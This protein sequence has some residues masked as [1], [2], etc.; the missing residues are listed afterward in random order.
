MRAPD[1]RP[2]PEP[3]PEQRV[4]RARARDDHGAS[5]PASE[6]SDP[7]R[8]AASV[9]SPG[10]GHEDAAPDGH[11]DATGKKRKRAQRTPEKCI[12]CHAWCGKSVENQWTSH[13]L[14]HAGDEVAQVAWLKELCPGMESAAMSEYVRESKRQRRVHTCHFRNASKV[15]VPPEPVEGKVPKLKLKEGAKACNRLASSVPARAWMPLE[16]EDFNL[17]GTSSG[18]RGSGSASGMVT[19]GSAGSGVGARGGPLTPHS[20]RVLRRVAIETD[21]GEASVA[22]QQVSDLLKRKTRELDDAE[23]KAA[24]ASVQLREARAQLDG[25]QLQLADERRRSAACIEDLQRQLAA[26]RAEAAMSREESARAMQDLHASFTASGTKLRYDML[27]EEGGDDEIRRKCKHLTGWSA[28]AFVAMWNVL[29]HDGA[30]DRLM[31][32]NGLE[33]VRAAKRVLGEDREREQHSRPG[34]HPAT[35]ADMFFY[36]WFVAKTG[37]DATVAAFM[38]GI[39]ES[40]ASKRFVSMTNFQDDFWQ[41]QFRRPTLAQL[42][43]ATPQEYQRV[44]QTDKLV[45]IIDGKELFIEKPAEPQA[46]RATW[47]EYKHNNTVKVLVAISP[48]GAALWCSDAYPG[49][50]DDTSIVKVSGILKWLEKGECVAADRGFEGAARALLLQGNQLV[51]PAK[52]RVGKRRP[53]GSREP[54]PNFTADEADDTSA[55]ANLRIHVERAI[56]NACKFNLVAQT[57]PLDRVDLIGRIFRVVFLVANNFGAPLVGTGR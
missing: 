9:P 27:L 21:S 11:E 1:R 53:D 24:S 3:E 34:R 35:W 42:Q 33:S 16:E 10:D 18:R 26:V 20:S 4:T 43:D 31:V 6:T 48:G 14:K 39:E 7:T 5:E 49:R 12:C 15:W 13:D 54:A 22:F 40:S 25:L 57:F 47:S 41:E 44:Y 50:I 28:E 46:Q 51:H 45:M 17:D 2:P 23:A 8:P 32:W 30:G 36:W 56:A 29:N 52:R 37:A 55:Q 38:F 19:P